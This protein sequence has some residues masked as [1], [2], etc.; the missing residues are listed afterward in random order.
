MKL[1]DKI[2]TEAQLMEVGNNIEHSVPYKHE[3]TRKLTNSQDEIS[4]YVFRIDGLDYETLI[5]ERQS[6]SWKYNSVMGTDNSISWFDVSFRVFDED[7]HQ[8]VNNPKTVYRVL[9]TV[10]KIILDY[11]KQTGRK[12]FSMTP[13]SESRA[14]IY[15]RFL[16]LLG[17]KFT[18]IPGKSGGCNRILFII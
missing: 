15:K 10:A 5:V 6:I 14:T 18:E 17:A 7:Y 16:Q 13:S 1:I 3:I 8:I 9:N 4:K 2:L 11:S 12:H